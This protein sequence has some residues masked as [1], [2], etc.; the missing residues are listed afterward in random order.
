VS[1]TEDP[2]EPLLTVVRGNPTA[3]EIAALVVVLS[4]LR[5][6]PAAPPEPISTDGWAA[7]WRGLR[8]T[9]RSGPDAWR[10]SARR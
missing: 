3:E 8:T 7:R 9:W 1:D 4:S 10:F 2:A 6:P 5:T